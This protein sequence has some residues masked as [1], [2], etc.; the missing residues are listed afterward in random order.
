[1]AQIVGKEIGKKILEL[2]GV[3]D[4]KIIEAHIHIMKDNF[5]TIDIK[6]YA[7]RENGDFIL[8]ED[9]QSIKKELKKYHLVEVEEEKRPEFEPDYYMEDGSKV[10]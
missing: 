9:E 2:F 3:K 6:R 7:T 10:K 5:I 4:S 8:T 1:M